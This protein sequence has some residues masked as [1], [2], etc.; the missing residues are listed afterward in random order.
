MSALRAQGCAAGR[1]G[2]VDSS[3][4]RNACPAGS[5]KLSESL[6]MHG[7]QGNPTQQERLGGN[8]HGAHGPGPVLLNLREDRSGVEVGQDLGAAA[9]GLRTWT[10]ATTSLCWFRISA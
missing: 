8:P 2:R 1:Y 3:R 7:M 4:R 10:T 9:W 6:G 5:R